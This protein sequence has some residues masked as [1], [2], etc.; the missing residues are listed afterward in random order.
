MNKDLKKDYKKS[1]DTLRDILSSIDPEGLQPGKEDGTPADE[2]DDEVIKIYNFISHSSEEIKLNKNLLVD[3]I[4]K[5]WM[6]NF[7]SNCNSVNEIVNRIVKE[8]F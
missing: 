7:S 5:I 4:C 8:L 6:K 1:I 3:E 2:Y